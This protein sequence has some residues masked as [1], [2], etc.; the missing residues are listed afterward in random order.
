PNRW[1]SMAAAEPPVAWSGALI[2]DVARQASSRQASWAS[3]AGAA[4]KLSATAV[5]AESRVFFNVVPRSVLVQPPFYPLDGVRRS[6]ESW[7]FAP[8]VQAPL[9]SVAGRRCVAGAPD[10]LRSQ[11]WAR[12]AASAPWPMATLIWSSPST[13]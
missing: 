8:R 7:R 2:S 9:L 10:W 12:V 4:M 1:A 3:A 13:R 6:V 11:L 5:A